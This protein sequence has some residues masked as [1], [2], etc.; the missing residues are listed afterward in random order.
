M[1][2]ELFVIVLC[3][4]LY[5]FFTRSSTKKL[6]DDVKVVFIST[7]ASLLLSLSAVTTN[8]E[9]NVGDLFNFDQ[10]K[11]DQTI[12][13]SKDG[14]KDI[15]KDLKKHPR[16]KSEQIAIHNLESIIGESCPTVNPDWLVWKGKSL[17]LDGYCKNQK[18]ALEFSGPQHTSWNPQNEPY[19]Q[20]FERIVRDV[21]KR[22]ICKRH[23]VTLIV[24]DLT[25]PRHNISAYI[26]S[27]LHDV[28]KHDE[29]SNYIAIQ[30]VKPY[31]NKQIEKELNLSVDM[32]AAKQI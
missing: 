24:I 26:K 15:I 13:Q 25:L 16:T 20:Y 5:V 18:I 2:V 17:E 21:A 8:L 4:F 7:L 10:T 9:K 22:K 28:G 11:N 1:F 6:I 29:P 12:N 14:G 31:R 23:N 27:R 19:E 32:A 3:V 30:K